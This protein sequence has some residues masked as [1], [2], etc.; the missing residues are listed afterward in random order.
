VSTW[1]TGIIIFDCYGLITYPPALKREEVSMAGS[2]GTCSS[3]FTFAKNDPAFG[4]V[5]MYLLS[6]DVIFISISTD[7]LGLLAATILEFPAFPQSRL[8]CSCR[9]YCTYLSW[10]DPKEEKCIFQTAFQTS[11]LS[12][13]RSFRLHAEYDRVVTDLV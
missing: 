12:I 4:N 7:R 3:P 1:H 6:I 11:L 13:L 5:E 8:P 2:I 10:N 9:S